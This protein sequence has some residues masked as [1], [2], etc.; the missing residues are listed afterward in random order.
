M[1][2]PVPVAL[3]AFF[4]T[5]C[6]PSPRDRAAL[7]GLRF[8]EQVAENPDHFKAYGH[9]LMWAFYSLSEAASNKE[10]KREARA[11]GE[12]MAKRWRVVYPKL[13]PNPNSDTVYFYLSGS[14]T[15]D[16][17][18]ASDPAMKRDIELT[19]RR[20]GPED[21]LLFDPSYEPIPHDH[22]EDCQRCKSRNARGV[23]ACRKCGA[24]L[25]SKDPFDILFDALITTYA[26]QRYGVP[27]GAD[28]E[29]ITR[30][31]P[32]MRP[33]PRQSNASVTYTIT[34]IV[35]VL[36]DYSRYKLK[37]EWLPQEFA[38]LKSHAQ[39][40]INTK[41]PETLG[42][43]I[44]SLQAFGIPDTDPVVKR[45][46]DFLL[47]HQNAD[48]SWG[49]LNEKD[50]YTRYHTTWTGIGGVMAYNWKGEGVTNAEALRRIGP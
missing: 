32:A 43:Y 41:D 47:E 12:R 14:L 34:H 9:D 21:F 6:S 25:T 4:L 31:I 16:L 1:I 33:Y 8:L 5:A 11:I 50:I 35:Y 27:L 7:R 18:G 13:P 20:Y 10:F 19:S 49:D 15:A 2:K 26:G 17:L 23:K 24:K 37:P 28:L 30:W 38:Y 36:N 48:G 29:D 39:E 3:F 22:P 44:D 46:I 42:E 40:T 45:G